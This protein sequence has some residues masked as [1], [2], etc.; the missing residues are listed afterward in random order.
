MLESALNF[1]DEFSSGT[2]AWIPNKCHTCF[3]PLSTNPPL[4]E[5]L[6]EQ[7]LTFFVSSEELQLFLLLPPQC[8]DYSDGQSQCFLGV[9][10]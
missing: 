2:K 5:S 4:N 6:K 10:V 9:P 8:V 1:R 3:M 7:K